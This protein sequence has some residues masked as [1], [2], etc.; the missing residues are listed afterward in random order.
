MGEVRGVH[1]G[2]RLRSG[3]LAGKGLLP[4][5]VRASQEE[6]RQDLGTEGL[7]GTDDCILVPAFF[8]TLEEVVARQ[9]AAQPDYRVTH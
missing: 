3:S 4:A 7:A 5:Q 2:A 6:P 1:G 9:N 8:P